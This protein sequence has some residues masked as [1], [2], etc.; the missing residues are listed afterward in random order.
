MNLISQITNYQVSS[1]KKHMISVLDRSISTVQTLKSMLLHRTNE[2][3][4]I[5]FIQNP[6]DHKPQLLT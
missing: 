4:I 1:P 5:Y 3:L 2:Y 6:S